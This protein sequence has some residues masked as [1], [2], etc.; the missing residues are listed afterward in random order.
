MRRREFI[1]LIGG[2]TAAWPLRTA[3][4]QSLERERQLI[5]V[6]GTSEDE[7]DKAWIGALIERLG[8]LGWKNGDNLR[9]VV[10]WWTGT[11]QNMKSV[12]SNTN[13]LPPD[14]YVAFSNLALA[15]LLPVANNVPVVF[16]GIGD[17]VGSGF[18]R[19][20]ARPGGNVTGF[21][22]YDASMGSKW[23][24]VLKDTIPTLTDVMALLY[25]ETPAHQAF[26][27]SIKAAA[28][29]YPVDVI[30][31][32]VHDAAEIE[33][34]ISSFG[35]REKGGIIILPHAVTAAHRDLITSLALRYRLPS[36][37]GEA[38]AIHSG[39]LI[40]Y[41]INFDNSFRRTAEYVDRILRGEKPGELPVQL[42]TKYELAFNLKTAQAIGVTIPSAMLMRADEVIE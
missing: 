11:P 7:T 35:T 15:T 6:M 10:R 40:Y 21:S 42:P 17:P 14:V 29:Q 39:N 34:V 20:L 38:G 2:A 33:R 9:I 27:Q 31:G 30:P 25:P 5:V 41:G 4:A 16:A 37:T 1:A 19:S 24:E 32:P 12:I 18:V 28:P 13:G 3:R 8:E 22:S 36:V 23:L 26:W